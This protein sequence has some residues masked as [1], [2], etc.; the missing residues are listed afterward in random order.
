MTSNTRFR[1]WVC[2]VG[3]A[4]VVGIAGVGI[5]ASASATPPDS[6]SSGAQTTVTEVDG[7]LPDLSNV[8]PGTA[9]PVGNV[10][11]DSLPA[12]PATTTAPSK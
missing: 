10:P 3:V 6:G 1:V 2:A 11:V 4:A 9:I 12:G 8:V 7:P 5:A